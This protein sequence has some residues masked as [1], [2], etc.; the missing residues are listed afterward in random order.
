M[1]MPGFSADSSLY[2]GTI[3]YHSAALS[4]EASG[5]P[6]SMALR[7]GPTCIPHCGP[8]TPSTGFPTGCAHTCTTIS[9][10]SQLESCSGCASP[11]KG[12]HFCGGICRNTTSDP[13][14]CG[15]CS[16]VCSGGAAC[17]NGVCACPPGLTNCSGICTD[18][19]SDPNNCGACGMT[20]SGSQ[21]CCQGTCVGTVPAPARGLGSNS[22]YFFDNT[23][24]NILGLSVALQVTQDMASNTGFSIQ[25]NANSPAGTEVDAWQQY[26][27]YIHDNSIKGFL[28]NFSN[29]GTPIVCHL[30]DLC[31]TPINNGLPAGYTLAVSLSTDDNSNVT[32][33]VYQVYDGD[34]NQLANK[35]VSVAEAGC[36]CNVGCT[37]F[38]SGDLS[39]ITTFTVDIVGPGNSS[40]ATFSAGVGNISYSSSGQLTPLSS[41]P[42]CVERAPVT[43]E[44][45]NAAYGTLSSCPGQTVTQQFS[46]TPV[47]PRVCFSTNGPCTGANGSSQCM[48]LNG[49]TQCCGSSWL[50]GHFPWIKGCSDGTVAAQGCGGPCW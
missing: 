49:A 4:G 5:S 42:I 10:D 39:P 37:G 19:S 17:A 11:C 21:T 48:T 26:G 7:T 23:C 44:T 41:V 8:C 15:A 46:V 14:N 1:N 20:C 12:G 29:R 40:A 43:A 34:G 25:L 2:N 33:A 50:W 36:N 32:A 6:V 35:S 45:S 18:T 16:T 13:N 28:E 27:F 30:E 3:Y 9:C 38:K 24:Q 22:N 31:S 47:T